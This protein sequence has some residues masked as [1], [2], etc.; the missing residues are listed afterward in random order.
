MVGEGTGESPSMKHGA[1]PVTEQASPKYTILES[2]AGRR[3]APSRESGRSAWKKGARDSALV[4]PGESL[5][6]VSVGGYL[7]SVPVPMADRRTRKN[8]GVT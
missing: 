5:V 8:G 1:I 2:P 3:A 4:R 6:V 7:M